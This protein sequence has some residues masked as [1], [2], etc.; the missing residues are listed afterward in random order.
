M[1]IWWSPDL[2][3]DFSSFSR[4]YA[5]ARVKSEP[6]KSLAITSEVERHMNLTVQGGSGSLVGIRLY[7]HY[8]SN[9]EQ[10]VRLPLM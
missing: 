6:A 2:F 9:E 7:V 3:P 5:L 10:G 8:K 1:P 4:K